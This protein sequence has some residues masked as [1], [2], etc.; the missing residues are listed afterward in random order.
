MKP[1]DPILFKN[2]SEMGRRLTADRLYDARERS[3]LLTLVLWFLVFGFHR[4]YLGQKELGIGLFVL[5][6][7]LSIGMAFFP[8]VGIALIIIRFVD[9]ALIFPL[10]KLTNQEIRDEIYKM[11]NLEI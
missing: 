9:L 11:A 7:I 8:P 2:R 1:I 3:V 10:L 6:M 5:V 4:Y